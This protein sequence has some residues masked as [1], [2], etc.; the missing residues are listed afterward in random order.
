[1]SKNV[2]LTYNDFRLL[3]KAVDAAAEWR[4]SLVGDP[5]PQPLKDFDAEIASMR[6]VLDKLRTAPVDPVAVTPDEMTSHIQS[7]YDFIEN[8]WDIVERVSCKGAP[9]PRPFLKRIMN[10]EY[11]IMEASA[12]T[13]LANKINL[14]LAVEYGYKGMEK[15]WNL[16][17]TLYEFEKVRK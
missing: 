17:K 9:D 8:E 4:G 5:D 7:A 10:G 16:E 1:M 15:G 11:I 3:R 6:K 12:E 2:P 13:K 14:V